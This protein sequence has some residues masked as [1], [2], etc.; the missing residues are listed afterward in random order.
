M[1]PEVHFPQTN[2]SIL[3]SS[4]RPSPKELNRQR[5]ADRAEQTKWVETIALFAENC[6]D[7]TQIRAVLK[8][9]TRV[10]LPANVMTSI[11]GTPQAEEKE[12]LICG[13]ME[14]AKI[15]CEHL[16]KKAFSLANNLTDIN[17]ILA[18]DYR[19]AGLNTPEEAVPNGT[20]L[21]GIDKALAESLRNNQSVRA[22]IIEARNP[23]HERST[24]FLHFLYFAK[25]VQAFETISPVLLELQ[26]VAFGDQV[27]N[28]VEQYS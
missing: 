25:E 26:T 3:K 2:E 17:K 27:K 15:A 6:N 18:C 13:N 11:T 7:S 5:R 19:V 1:S 16:L 12:N 22:E 20:L 9:L 8:T 28:I 24:T 23:E 10:R 4:Q 21:Y 14:K